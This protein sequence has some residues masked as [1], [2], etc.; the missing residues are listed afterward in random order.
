MINNL[1]HLLNDKLKLRADKGNLR[2]LKIPEQGIDFFSNDYLG[3]ARNPAFHKQLSEEINADPSI[4]GGATGSRLISGNSVEKMRAEQEIAVFH[5]YPASLLFASGYMANLALLS[6]LPGRGDTIL[7]DE[8]IHRSVHDGASLSAAQKWKFKHNDLNSLEDKLRRASGQSYVVVES[9]YSM[10]G[11]FASL[12]ELVVLTRRYNAALIVDEAHAFGV[13]GYGLVHQ[14]GLQKHVFATV[15]TYGKALGAHGAAVLGEELL[16]SYLVNFASAFIYSTACPDLFAR[17]I[18]L[19]YA[20]LNEHSEFS[21]QLKR[22][23]AYFRQKKIS[24]ASDP[25]S[26]VQAIIIPRH[27]VLIHLQQ[28]LQKNGLQVYAIYSPTV[29]EEQER[30]RICLHQYNTEEEIDALTAEINNVL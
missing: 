11:D 1:S 7:M 25:L 18:R 14:Y 29:R 26:P 30:L 6:A 22:R 13:F 21:A 3:L 8:L 28:R 10:D 9:L 20:F 15:I 12:N 5:G 19:G 27:E 2:S 4:L 16:K 17:H 23:I 24:S